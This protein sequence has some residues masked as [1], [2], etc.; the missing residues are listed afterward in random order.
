[1]R[2]DNRKMI[3]ALDRADRE[4]YY[5]WLTDLSL[6]G[7]DYKVNEIICFAA[8]EENPLTDFAMIKKYDMGFL[9]ILL[10]T[11]KESLLRECM[12]YAESVAA[13]F[14][15]IELR[16]PYPAVLDSERIQR[17]FSVTEP[18]EP[19]SPVYYIHSPKELASAVPDDTVSV[20][21]YRESDKA[22]I[23]QAVCSGKLDGASMNANMFVPCTVFRDVKWYIL[24]VNGEIAGYLRGECGYANVYDIGWLY[25]EPRFRGRGYAVRLVLY[26]SEEL[27]ASGAVPH[28]GY[29]ISPSSE[30]V[31][32]KCG[33][34]CDPEI[35]ECRTLTLKRAD[36][37]I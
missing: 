5:P 6:A 10:Y 9:L 33:F 26:F 1:M 15:E 13:D 30:R 17:R 20:T 35:I 8:D 36:K 22:E 14:S 34:V 19:A 29:A 4:R 3:A 21:P 28:Y 24:R 27:F 23:A 25:V 12:D 7:Q 37:A 32:E 2:I 16:T 11:E 31:A 18:E